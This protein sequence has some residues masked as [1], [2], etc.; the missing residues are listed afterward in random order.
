[1]HGGT[2]RDTGRWSEHPLV[3]GP[4]REA[5]T[6]CLAPCSGQ[7]EAW[8]G[9]GTLPSPGSVPGVTRGDWGQQVF[10]PHIC[11][12]SPATGTV[13]DPPARTLTGWRP[14]RSSL[15]GHR[16]LLPGRPWYLW[17]GDTNSPHKCPRFLVLGGPESCV[18]PARPHMSGTG[19][20]AVDRS[21]SPASL[22]PGTWHAGGDRQRGHPCPA[23]VTPPSCPL[24]AALGR[25]CRPQFVL[26]HVDGVLAAE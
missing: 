7:P 13:P 11:T 1:M 6:A 16:Q 9:L 10:R 14:G 2:R 4:G 24:P 23:S 20:D 12:S 21:A 19:A 18:A 3:G 8:G 5:V 25:F 26:V 17:K 15:S 22:A